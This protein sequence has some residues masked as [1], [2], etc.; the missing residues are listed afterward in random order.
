MFRKVLFLDES[1]IGFPRARGDVPIKAT[2]A[3]LRDLFSPRT[4]GCS[5][6]IEVRKND[7]RVF[8]A[9]AGM[10]RVFSVWS[11]VARS[12]PRARGDVPLR[13]GLHYTT[14]GFSPR[15]RG[16][17]DLQQAMHEGVD[18]FPAHAGMFLIPRM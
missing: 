3:T 8:P 17:S 5:A 7:V 18:V 9:H 4:R 1:K 13:I 12:F 11:S 14:H 6:K 2:G 10:F 16:C 15:T